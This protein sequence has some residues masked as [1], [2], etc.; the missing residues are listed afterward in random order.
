MAKT[1]S[2][3]LQPTIE[4]VLPAQSAGQQP[5]IRIVLAWQ[6]E[7]SNVVAPSSGPRFAA[8]PRALVLD[9]G[10]R[11][12]MAAWAQSRASG[13]AVAAAQTQSGR[14]DHARFDWQSATAADR[15]V[16]ESGHALPALGHLRLWGEIGLQLEWLDLVLIVQAQGHWRSLALHSVDARQDGECRTWLL[17]D[18]DELDAAD[19][20]V[21]QLRLAIADPAAHLWVCRYAGLGAFVMLAVDLARLGLASMAETAIAHP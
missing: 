7:A 11:Q 21:R 5:N 18:A 10:Q 6:S 12:A 1:E 15:F 13:P 20:D 2:P 9:A 14:L 17:L 8:A 4:I 16:D 19:L 3:A